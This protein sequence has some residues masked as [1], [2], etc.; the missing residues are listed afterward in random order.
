[1]IFLR[2]TGPAGRQEPVASC[3]QNPP[4]ATGAIESIGSHFGYRAI[5]FDLGSAPVVVVGFK[6][7]PLC[8]VVVRQWEQASALEFATRAM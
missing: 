3:E 1:M 5:R 7:L 8:R 2:R 6:A 4:I